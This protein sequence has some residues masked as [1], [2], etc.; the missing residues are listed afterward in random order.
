MLGEFGGP[1]P[2]E[3]G[4][5]PE[6]KIQRYATEYGLYSKDAGEKLMQRIEH[7]SISTV[8]DFLRSLAPLFDREGGA[9][10]TSIESTAEALSV[11]KPGKQDL[12][13]ALKLVEGWWKG[14]E[15]INKKKEKGKQY[16]DKL[17]ATRHFLKGELEDQSGK[18]TGMSNREIEERK[19]KLDKIKVR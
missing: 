11:E 2:K 18:Y 6:A 19:K 1:S 14:A 13:K 9:M 5:K 8:A 17:D 3:M 4:I 10:R 7:T 15:I 12:E 16:V